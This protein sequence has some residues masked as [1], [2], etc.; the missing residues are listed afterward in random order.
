[1][2][3]Y[4]FPTVLFYGANSLQELAKVVKSK[5]LNNL[6]MI[7]DPGLVSVGL[8]KQTQKI[9]TKSKLKI[10]IFDGVNPNPVEDNV[11][12]GVKKYQSGKYDGIIALGGGSAMDVAKTIR[13]M[14]VHDPPLAQY[15]DA[16]GGEEK[17]VNPLPPLY[18]IPTT[19][20]TGSEVGRSSVITLKETGKK[21][22]FFHPDLIPDIAVLD[23]TL[24]TGLPPHITAA[25]G[26][27][28]FTHCMEAYLVDNFHPM[29]DAIAVEGMKLILEN[30]P[31]VIKDPENIDARGKMLLAASMGAIAFQKGLGMIH[32]MAH[33][34][35]AEHN[36]HHGLANAMLIPASL[37][38]SI[39]KALDEKMV[40]LIKKFKNIT[41]I[42][43]C[44]T[45]SN[46]DNL[47]YLL[48]VFINSAG[49]NLGLENEN[50]REDQIKKLSQ[51]AFE[52]SCHVTHPF[53]VT[54]KDFA[55]VLSNSL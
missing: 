34:L 19:A 28:A 42:I 51:L 21:T 1:M 49:I 32:S 25:T 44:N 17:I 40:S 39:K 15:D 22:I 16:F 23:P 53:P 41:E 30:L 52:D 3:Q 20:G 43:S 9:I 10:D 35:S 27:D 55:I 36:L 11:T 18:A 12:K 37:E 6:L 5:G 24:T 47:P 13:F 7:T 26:M 48:R 46:I 38:F 4:N 31:K 29:A 33:P 45:L 54:I 50:I 2:I 14:A 8:A